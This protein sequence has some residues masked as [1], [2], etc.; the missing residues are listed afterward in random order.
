M[1]L[2]WLCREVDQ[3][4]LSLLTTCRM[5]LSPMFPPSCVFW[6]YV[7]SVPGIGV[8]LLCLWKAPPQI[9]HNQKEELFLSQLGC[10]Q[11]IRSLCCR[12]RTV[13]GTPPENSPLT[14]GAGWEL[15]AMVH[16]HSGLVYE[17]DIVNSI[18]CS[19]VEGIHP[20]GEG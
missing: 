4:P 2:A 19:P 15:G 14:P 18:L 10:W 11:V 9:M 5:L 8:L 17:E 13:R 20:W 12:S 3:K 1:L 16:R 6:M 7:R